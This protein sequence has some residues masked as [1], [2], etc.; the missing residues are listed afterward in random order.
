MTITGFD[1]I[2]FDFDGVVVESA[3]IKT[4]AFFALYEE[5]GP[6]VLEAAL[7]HHRANGGIS[8]RKKIRHI[9]RRHLGIDLDDDAL[10]ALCRRFSELVEDAV[11]AC[12]WVPGAEA[13]LEAHHR[14]MALFVVSGTPHEELL[15]I[16]DRRGIRRYFV[17]IFGSPPEKPPTIR[18]ILSRHRLDRN[19]VL[20]VGDAT[21]DHAAAA[22]TGLGFVGRVAAGGPDPF[23]PG[24]TVI[25]DLTVL[26]A[27]CRG[28]G[29]AV[30]AGGG[31][32]PV[33]MQR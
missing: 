17:E 11:V 4:R 2:I 5:H 27:I 30:P 26:P 33:G 16:I 25:G 6:A 20:F 21:T 9:H 19:R 8:R 31:S 13:F 22:E 32:V 14:R 24:T 3:D 1:A 10:E 29:P 7:A 15:R 18:S 12:D 28:V 23:P